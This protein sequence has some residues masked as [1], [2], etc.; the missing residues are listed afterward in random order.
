MTPLL[1]L[2]LVGGLL[3]LK[4]AAC[5]D[6]PGWLSQTFDSRECRKVLEGVR[7]NSPVLFRTEPGDAV[8]WSTDISKAQPNPNMLA[9]QGKPSSNSRGGHLGIAR[10]GGWVSTLARMVWG[11]FLEKNLPR[12]N[13]HL[14]GFGGV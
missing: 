3:L 14:L 11:T 6:G 5:Q 4:S 12:S 8:F 13:G 9:A 10:K 2:A 7:L 1:N